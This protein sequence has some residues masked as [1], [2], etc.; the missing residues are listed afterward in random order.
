MGRLIV[1][2]VAAITISGCAVVGAVG[3]AAVDGM[4]Y[5]F[6]GEEESFPVSMRG[7]L[8]AA[9]RVLKKSAF[10][11]NVLEPV[12]DGYLMAFGNENLDGKLSFKKLTESLTT[13]DAKVRNGLLRQDSV[14]RALIRVFREEVKKVK[15]Q[16]R[17]DFRGYRNIRE[18][19]DINAKRVGWYLPGN[20]LDV[21]PLKDSEWLRIKMPSGKSAYLKGSIAAFTRK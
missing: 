17:F 5:L 13:V 12:D 11:A 8:A 18:N 9:Q 16:D 19:P 3:G 2:A 15:S 6:K 20:F 7:S 21:K 14:E 10:R 1:A 4:V